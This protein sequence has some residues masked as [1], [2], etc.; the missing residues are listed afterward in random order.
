MEQFKLACQNDDL[1][2]VKL[3]I[4][5]N[6]K[7]LN[8]T[9][10]KYKYSALLI[11]ILNDSRKVYKYLLKNKFNPNVVTTENVTPLIT[12]SNMGN[13]YAVKELLKYNVKRNLRTHEGKSALMQA[14]LKGHSNIVKI[15]IKHGAKI[16]YREKIINKKSSK[17][18]TALEMAQLC[19]HKETVKHLLSKKNKK[20]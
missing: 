1:K 20:I 8:I 19:G 11:S 18:K 17:K 10:G 16:H 9:Y 4:S 7:L 12:A 6:K 15:L 2:T 13:I 5:K 3:M 14:S